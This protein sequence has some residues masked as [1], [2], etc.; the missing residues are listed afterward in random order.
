MFCNKCGKE[1]SPGV[2]FCQGC[3][4]PVGEVNPPVESTAPVIDKPVIDNNVVPSTRVVE[5]KPSNGDGVVTNNTIPPKKKSI[6]PIIIIILVVFFLFIIG[7]VAIVLLLVKG[8][9]DS[10]D[11]LVCESKEG[12]ITLIYNDTDLLG[13]T[14]SGGITYD[15]DGQ[16]ELAKQMGIE[17][18]LEKFNDWFEKNTSGTCKKVLKDGNTPIEE[19]HDIPAGNGGGSTVK[20]DSKE[21]GEDKYGYVDVPKYWA[22]FYDTEANH[23]VQYSYANLY[24][25]T[26]D[27]VENTTTTAKLVADS[28]F[29]EY[30]NKSEVTDV[31]IETVKIGKER[32]TGYK[33]SM[34]YTNEKTYLDTYWFDIP[35][36]PNMHYI[37][38]EGPKGYEQYSSIIDTYRLKK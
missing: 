30:S 27:Y 4:N 17:A 16:K 20:S 1:I 10:N 7:I 15:L 24:I 26:M 21:V 5:V 13:Y 12:N 23:S 25:L 8:V 28:F 6:V 11:K 9:S 35:G 2:K 38:L 19:D 29:K 36:D 33:V 3:G 18:Y 32:Y 22:T 31:K 34:Y 37:A 14:T